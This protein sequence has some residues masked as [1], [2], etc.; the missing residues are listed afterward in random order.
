M[1]TPSNLTKLYVEELQDLWSANTQM[2]EVVREMAKTA[3]DRKLGDR[4]EKSADGIHKHSDMLQDLIERSGGQ[5]REERCKGMEGLVKEARRHSVERS[6]AGAV[7]DLAI[8]AQYQ[9]MCHYG[10]A[11]FGTAKAYSQALGKSEDVD[12]LDTAL[13]RIYQS[14]EYMTELAERSNELNAAKD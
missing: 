14:D 13:Q 6:L 3:E 8:I 9:R 12:K 4:L 1:A 2:M 10:I 5:A 11:G 7:R